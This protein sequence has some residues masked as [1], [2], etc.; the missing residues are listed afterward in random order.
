LISSSREAAKQAKNV[1]ATE[2]T[3]T[4]KKKRIVLKD[5]N[6]E[7]LCPPWLNSSILVTL[8]PV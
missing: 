1:K 3:E 2:V 8:D 5:V 6:S 7:S 4:M